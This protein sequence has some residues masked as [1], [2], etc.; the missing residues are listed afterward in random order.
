MP[1]GAVAAGLAG[2][3]ATGADCVAGAAWGEGATGDGAWG[4]GCAVFLQLGQ[5]QHEQHPKPR[6][7]LRPRSLHFRKKAIVYIPGCQWLCS[8]AGAVAWGDAIGAASGGAA[9]G[10][11]FWGAAAGIVC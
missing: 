3:L 2:T 6:P 4:D 11:V 9:A 7:S 1:A 5:V 8:H 10:I